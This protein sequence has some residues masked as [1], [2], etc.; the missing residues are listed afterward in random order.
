MRYDIIDDIHGG[1]ASELKFMLD[2]LGYHRPGRGFRRTDRRVMFVGDFV[3]RGP[4]I[5]EMVSIVRAMVDAGDTLAVKG[6][7]LEE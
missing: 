7:L 6:N 5:G 3:D 1:H 4:A 2:S